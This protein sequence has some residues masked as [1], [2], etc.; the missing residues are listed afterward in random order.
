M[1]KEGNWASTGNGTA[2]PRDSAFVTDFR[3]AGT[4]AHMGD[5]LRSLPTNK[6]SMLVSAKKGKR[7]AAD[8]EEQPGPSHQ[9]ETDRQCA[10]VQEGR[11]RGAKRQALGTGRASMPVGPS[12]ASL[13]STS[14]Q[15][16][17][18]S[19]SMAVMGRPVGALAPM[20]TG[21]RGLSYQVTAPAATAN[22]LQLLP[23]PADSAPALRDRVRWQRSMP[24]KQAGVGSIR[25]PQLAGKPAAAR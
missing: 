4:G 5:A 14:N 10:D 22:G 7:P 1:R 2:Q 9:T 3:Q 13:V 11:D 23:P 15:A 17:Y 25:M 18:S 21:T 16:Q 20:Q 6:G 24:S 12:G 8:L 19:L